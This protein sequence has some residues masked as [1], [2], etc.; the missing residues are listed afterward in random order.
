MSRTTPRPKTAAEFGRDAGCPFCTARLGAV[1][2]I[3]DR[4]MLISGYGVGTIGTV[5]L[6]DSKL[7]HDWFLIQADNEPESTQQIVHPWVLY[8][9]SDP[10]LQAPCWLPSLSMRELADLDD[11]IVKTCQRVLAKPKPSWNAQLF[12]SVISHCWQRRLP[13]NGDEISAVLEAHGLPKTFKSK[14]KQAYSDG[15]G[16]LVYTHGRKPVKKKRMPPLTI[17]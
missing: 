15:V 10:G 13:L 4:I 1:P 7:P 8:L 12:Y 9:L 3:G 16:L 2:S 14:S 6:P 11:A 5:V 17:E